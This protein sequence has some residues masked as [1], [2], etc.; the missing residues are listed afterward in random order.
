DRDAGRAPPPA[1][2]S[3]AT[4]QRR[5]AAPRGIMN[6]TIGG[7]EMATEQHQTPTTS[8]HAPAHGT[9]DGHHGGHEGPRGHG[10][11]G[12]GHTAGKHAGH[13]TEAFRRRFWWCLLLT[14]PVV[15][16]SHM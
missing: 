16:T 3:R 9:R 4:D 7:P 11:H 5:R 8:G 1:T 10:N 6:P 14:V 13:H 15:A 2:T 12:G